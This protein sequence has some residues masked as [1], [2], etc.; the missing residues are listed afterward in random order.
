ME[1]GEDN[2]D[3]LRRIDRCHDSLPP[4]SQRAALHCESHDAPRIPIASPLPSSSTHHPTYLSPLALSLRL[5][6]PFSI[7][8]GGS[9]TPHAHS[10]A[11]RA[12]C[13]A[14]E[15]FPIQGVA[16]PLTNHPR[17]YP[18]N[19]TLTSFIRHSASPPPLAPPL[20][21][22]IQSSVFPPPCSLLKHRPPSVN[23]HYSPAAK[24]SAA[25]FLF[26]SPRLLVTPHPFFCPFTSTPGLPET[27]SISRT[28]RLFDPTLGI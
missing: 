19:A 9:T 13:S 15:G 24:R 25:P 6:P 1:G 14:A 4:G 21:I 16:F 7:P 11:P 27:N 12:A 28:R 18:R 26:Y 3:T 23:I 17:L 22:F 10:D 8:S 2:T 5:R 20:R